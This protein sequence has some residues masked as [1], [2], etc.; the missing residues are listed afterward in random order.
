MIE[1]AQIAVA[2]VT[3][4]MTRATRNEPDKVK[5]FGQRLIDAAAPSDLHELGIAA[6]TRDLDGRVGI[7][8]LMRVLHVVD[9]VVDQPR[10]TDDLIQGL[11][12]MPSKMA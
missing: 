3:L 2:A 9:G 6:K 8:A 1:D 5:L 4:D 7:D 11:S 12:P 10:L